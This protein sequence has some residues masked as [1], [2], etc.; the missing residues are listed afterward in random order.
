MSIDDTPRQ[1][2]A[3][4]LAGLGGSLRQWLTQ[5]IVQ[6]TAARGCDGTLRLTRSWIE[7]LQGCPDRM[8]AN[9]RRA[10][11]D[12]DCAVARTVPGRTDV[13]PRC[14]RRR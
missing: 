4:D 6:G 10:G 14:A 1:P 8:E 3:A 13:R 12:C 9:R 11:V 7:E 2:P 5:V